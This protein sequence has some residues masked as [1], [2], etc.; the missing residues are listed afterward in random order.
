MGGVDDWPP[1]E[2][3]RSAAHAPAGGPATRPTRAEPAAAQGPQEVPVTGGRRRPAAGAARRT[4]RPGSALAVDHRRAD[5]PAPDDPFRGLYV[6]DEAVDRLLG[7]LRADAG[8][9]RRRSPV[10]GRPGPADDAGPQR[11]R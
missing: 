11:R 6:N 7:G 5:D 1:R 4:S 2:M 8:L 10:V 3:S 9:R